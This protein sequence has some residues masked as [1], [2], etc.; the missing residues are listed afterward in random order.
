MQ[1]RW[2]ILL[3]F[4]NP[5]NQKRRSKAFDLTP[6]PSLHPD[7]TYQPTLSRDIFFIVDLF[8]LPWA[9]LW[10]EV[11]RRRRRKYSN[12]NGAKKSGEDGGKPSGKL[13]FW[14]KERDR[15]KNR[16][17]VS[18]LALLASFFKGKKGSDN[19]LLK[20]RR[21]RKKEVFNY[22]SCSQNWDGSS[23]F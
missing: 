7:I 13:G 14:R 23:I 15:L 22:I 20:H 10:E 16:G 6:G 3:Q 11:G 18:A 4:P 19:Y 8:S 9:L 12:L 17:T 21:K 5:S 2:K 1:S